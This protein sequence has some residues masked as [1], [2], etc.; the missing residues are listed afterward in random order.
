MFRHAYAIFSLIE[1]QVIRDTSYVLHKNSFQ[2]PSCKGMYTPSCF[3]ILDSANS[4]IYS[5]TFYSIFTLYVAIKIVINYHW[6]IV[7]SSCSAQWQK[8]FNDHGIIFLVSDT[9]RFC[10]VQQEHMCFREAII[11]IRVSKTWRGYLSNPA[12]LHMWQV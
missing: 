4:S 11:L 6:C 2:F 12:R 3:C 7:H 8:C 9:G 5:C 10:N 1:W